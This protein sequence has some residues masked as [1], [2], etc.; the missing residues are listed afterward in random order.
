MCR[1]GRGWSAAPEK[2]E[3]GQSHLTWSSWA[4]RSHEAPRAG[5][6]EVSAHLPFLSCVYFFFLKNR[7]LQKSLK[8]IFVDA[9]AKIF[10]WDIMLSPPSRCLCFL[11]MKAFFSRKMKA[12]VRKQCLGNYAT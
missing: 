7:F 6:R 1:A 3:Q 11:G 8:A 2:P 12:N 9:A 5:R 10:Q 4:C